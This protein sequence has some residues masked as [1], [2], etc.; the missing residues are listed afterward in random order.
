MPSVA[1][2]PWPLGV[3]GKMVVLMVILTVAVVFILEGLLFPARVRNAPP[4]P[5]GSPGRSRRSASRPDCAASTP[6]TAGR[7][8]AA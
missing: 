3:E 2:S 4:D 7:R 1:M 6:A 8:C 5:A